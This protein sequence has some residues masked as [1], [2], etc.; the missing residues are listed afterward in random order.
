MPAARRPARS[1]PARILGFAVRTVLV[2]IVFSVV[3]VVAY[4]FVAVPLTWPMA[5]DALAGRH[6]ERHWVA[7]G[8]IAPAVPRAAIGAEDAR[9]CAHRGFDFGAMEAAAEKNAAGKKLRGGSTISQ[10]TAKNAFLWPGRSYL[11][12]GLEAWFTVLIEQIWGKRRIMEVYLNIAEMGPGVYG[13]DAAARRYF[14][15]PANALSPAQAARIVAI[16]PQPIKRSAEAPKGYTRKY[17][18]RIERRIRVVKREAIDGCLATS[19]A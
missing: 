7:L 4:R 1:L 10:Q 3:W 13:V 2:L 9:F 14:D 15:V 18:R 19:A 5:R 17:A 11:R 6:V 12:K 16:L 8:D